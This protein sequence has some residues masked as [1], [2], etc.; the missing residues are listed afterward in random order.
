MNGCCKCSGSLC[1]GNPETAFLTIDGVKADTVQ[2]VMDMIYAG[3]GSMAGDTEDFKCVLDMLEINT[4]VVDTS[5][6]LDVSKLEEILQTI[7]EVAKTQ[8]S[9]I[10]HEDSEASKS[11]YEEKHHKE[12]SK[13]IRRQE[14]EK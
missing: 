1:N 13:A 12:T 2:Y 4:I 11:K 9:S 7:E 10:D 14:R 8:E 6:S 5:T 3:S